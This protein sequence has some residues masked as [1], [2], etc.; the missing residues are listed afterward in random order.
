[1]SLSL[2]SVHFKPQDLPLSPH[3]L[4]I[5]HCKPY[6]HNSFRT[7][8]RCLTDTSRNK[9]HHQQ[10]LCLSLIDV[11]QYTQVPQYDPKE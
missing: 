3:H 1:M 5:A 6:Q 8:I 4:S 2:K 10:P 9:F 7:N 11:Q